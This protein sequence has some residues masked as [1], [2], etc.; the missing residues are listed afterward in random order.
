MCD[1][2]VSSSLPFVKGRSTPPAVEWV[3]LW[4]SSA[5][6]PRAPFPHIPSSAEIH[7]EQS[8]EL[9][10]AQASGG[11][12]VLKTQGSEEWESGAP[13]LFRFDT[14]CGSWEWGTSPGS[15]QE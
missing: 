3:S 9:V 5:P 4:L 12:G 2:P 8:L 14:P 15:G 10:R 11:Q 7:Q 6:V 13:N 1:Y